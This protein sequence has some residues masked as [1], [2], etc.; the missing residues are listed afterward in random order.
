MIS[1]M[2]LTFSFSVPSDKLDEAQQETFR[3]LKQIVDEED[4]DLTQILRILGRV[5]D[6]LNLAVETDPFRFVETTLAAFTYGDLDGEDLE[7][8]TATLK[9]FDTLASWNKSQW[10]SILRKY[11]TENPSVSVLG[12]PSQKLYETQKVENIERTEGYKAKYGEEGLKNLQ[13][14]LDEAQKKN[15]EPVPESILNQFHAPDISKIRFIE[16]KMASAGTSS[17]NTPVLDQ[18]IQSLVEK[19]IPEGFNLDLHFEHYQSQFVTVNF[20]VSTREIDEELLPLVDVFFAEMFALPLKLADGTMVDFETAVQK[21][22]ADTL[23]D[24]IDYG[25]EGQFE[26]YLTFQLQVRCDKYDLAVQWLQNA[27]MWTQFT[28]ERL[29]IILHKYMN[30]LAERKRRCSTVAFSLLARTM[31][32]NRSLRKAADLFETDEYFKDLF[33]SLDDP[34]GVSTLQRNLAKARQSLLN[35]DSIKVLV[36]GDVTKLKNPVKTWLPFSEKQFSKAI[37][38]N[39]NIPYLRDARSENGINV[40]TIALITPMA[41]SETSYAYVVGKG[42]IDFLDQD[43]PVIAV[44]CEFL[45]TLE[46]P[47]WRAVRGAGL[48]YGASMILN[49]EE[50]LIKLV[51][52]RGTNSGEAIRVCEL[53]V[54]DFASGKTPIESH[55]LEGAKNALVHSA[56]TNGENASLVA[57]SN[58]LNFKLKNRDRS[59]LK[60]HLS[61]VQK[62]TIQDVEACF[63]KYFLPLFK[64]ESSMVFI[65]CHTSMTDA[66]KEQ[67]DK[68]GYKVEV[69]AVVGSEDDDEFDSEDGSEDDSEESDED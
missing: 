28:E 19:D 49:V 52:Q 50:G 64:P 61:R 20:L 1:W 4:I 68:A 16:T 46:G 41:S 36:T 7:A 44:C 26:D 69:G 53:L 51:I 54:S 56:A 2:K 40:S 33:H 9:K 48:A 59:Y 22:K 13:Q 38:H 21:L 55:M 29:R 60:N 62:V 18:E 37:Q 66:L 24:L 12:K 31:W 25:I 47:M 6:K 45:Q 23:S 63:K 5:K 65:A 15:N 11:L 10:L 3:V 34:D 17:H 39:D 32:T 67:L 57:A 14:L 8:W 43:I 30:G 42:P 27:L 35:S 58:Y